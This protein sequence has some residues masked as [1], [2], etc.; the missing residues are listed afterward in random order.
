MNIDGI[1][2]ERH[3]VENI[4][5]TLNIKIVPIVGKGTLLDGVEIVRQGYESRVRETPPEGIVMR[6]E[7]ALFNRRGERVISKI[8][9]KDVT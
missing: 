9:M 7:I 5:D 3:N 1:W 4:A 8:N 6:P 2:R